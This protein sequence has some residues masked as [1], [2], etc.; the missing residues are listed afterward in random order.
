MV[1]FTQ[2]V[3]NACCLTRQA[4]RLKIAWMGG[5][6]EVE[7][8]CTTYPERMAILVFIYSGL[9]NKPLIAQYKEN[10]LWQQSNI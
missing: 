5:F 2:E 10:K 3:K 1:K 8:C 7:I 9:H 4:H 6:F